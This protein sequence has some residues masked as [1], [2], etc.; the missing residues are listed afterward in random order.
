VPNPITPGDCRAHAAEC[1]E[2]AREEKFHQL[3]TAFV[4]LSRTWATLARQLDRLDE[5]KK[6]PTPT[7]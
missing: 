3:Y 4:N 6:S 1:L 2:L 7:A 5:M